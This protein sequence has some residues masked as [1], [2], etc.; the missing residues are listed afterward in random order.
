M[1]LRVGIE[2][3]LAAF[4]AAHP[5][6][7][8]AGYALGIVGFLLSLGWLGWR[9]HETTTVSTRSSPAL[10]SRTVRSLAAR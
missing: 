2:A 8:R 1:A 9:A 7:A 5:W 6:R 3:R 10:R 4:E